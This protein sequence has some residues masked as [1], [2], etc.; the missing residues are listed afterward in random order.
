MIETIYE[1]PAGVNQPVNVGV[2]EMVNSAVNESVSAAVDKTSISQS[3][4][5]SA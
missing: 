4:R 3:T 5:E 2:K 1:T